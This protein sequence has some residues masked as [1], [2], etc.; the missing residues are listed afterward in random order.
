MLPTSD[1]RPPISELTAQRTLIGSEIVDG[2]PVT[3]W[4]STQLAD[5]AWDDFLQSTP[6]GQFQ[7]SSMWAQYKAV[8]GWQPIRV[9]LIT[10]DR[11]IGG[12]QILWR[13]KHFVRI[14][15]VSKGPVLTITDSD[16]VEFL[17]E[18][19]LAIVR[20][21]RLSALVV[22]PPDNC[23]TFASALIPYGFALDR[24]TKVIRSTLLVDVDS[25]I[26][27]I[28]RGLSKYTL[29]K[30]RQGKRRGLVIRQGEF[31]DCGAFFN[32]MLAT[33]SRQAVKK[34]NPSSTE[35]L[36]A[37]WR[38][39]APKGC[40]RITLAQA[41]DQAISGLLCLPFGERCTLWKKGWTSERSDLHPNESLTFEALE[42]AH[43]HGYTC[44]DFAGLAPTIA[45][46]LLKHEPLCDD[47]KRSRDFFNICFGGYPKMLP[48]ALLWFRNG[49][50][51]F[52]YRTLWS[53][54]P[55][56]A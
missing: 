16:L 13:T 44:C 18:Q 19:F 29:K 4:L 48:S 46:A 31:S 10:D 49:F 11:V 6:L 14:G 24:L 15:Y 7:Q 34:V 51:R 33:C 5:S 35:S 50:L 9:V 42:W 20:T 8:E 21:N 40:L 27:E 1:L 36:Q 22:Q 30:V 25:S 17:I 38:F 47:D 3:A 43:D 55:C 41:Q 52:A 45:N 53:K 23:S 26:A 37:L 28:A 56:W 54:R 32:L 39:F 12:F 2:R